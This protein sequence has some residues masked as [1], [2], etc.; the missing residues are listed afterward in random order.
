MPAVSELE[1]VTLKEKPLDAGIFIDPA[2]KNDG[3]GVEKFLQG[4][5][6]FYRWCDWILWKSF[7]CAV[8]VEKILRTM[9]GVAKIYLM[10][11][12]KDKEVAKQRLKNE[13]VDIEL[14]KCLKEAYGEH[15]EAFMWNKLVPV[16]ENVGDSNLGIYDVALEIKAIGLCNA[17]RFFVLSSADSVKR[18]SRQ[19]RFMEEKV[20][21]RD[22][23][24]RETFR[25]VDP[26]ILYYGKGKLTVFPL[27]PN[28]VVAIV[29][30][31]IVVNATLAAMTKHVLLAKKADIN[32]YHLLLLFQNQ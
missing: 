18:D 30:A 20:R 21:T 9:P 29:P 10:I 28:C 5:V 22:I 1:Q 2:V 32:I 11:R 19:G 15:Y 17:V 4:K 12:A 8:L 26:V 6:F 3:V 24:G 16:V 7:K 25:L 14:F 27:N 31:D 13:I 23:M